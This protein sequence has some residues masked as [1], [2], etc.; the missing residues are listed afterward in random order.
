MDG[1]A[2][3]AHDPA[4]MDAVMHAGLDVLEAITAAETTDDAIAAAHRVTGEI[5]DVEVLQRIAAALAVLA[6]FQ[7]GPEPVRSGEQR[8]ARFAQVQTWVAAER[9]EAMWQA[10]S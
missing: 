5:D 8:V 10:G 4:P 9:L 6:V 3:T 7:L 1:F 2:V